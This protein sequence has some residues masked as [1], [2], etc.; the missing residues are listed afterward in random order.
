[1]Y[2]NSM[3]YYMYG[4]YS[5]VVKRSVTTKNIIYKYYNEFFLQNF[6]NVNQIVSIC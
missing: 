3:S 4:F 6:M 5:Y 2:N 1:M